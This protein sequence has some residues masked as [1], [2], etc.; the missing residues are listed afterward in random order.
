MNQ[1][2]LHSDV[3]HFIN[4]NLHSDTHRLLLK[5]S[6]FDK[7]SSKDLVTQIESK[8]RCQK[9]LPLWYHTPG[10][11]YPPTLSIEQ[12]SSELTAAYKA[13][14]ISGKVLDATGGL[15]VD[16]F[17]FSKNTDIVYHIENQNLISKIAQHNFKVLGQN[18][19]TCICEEA[20]KFIEN[21]P[22]IY[23]WI[24]IDPAR[25]DAQK[26]KVFLLS[27]C[28]PNVVQ[29][30]PLLQ[31]KSQ[32]VLIKTSPI[33]DISKTL[34]EIPSVKEI[35]IVAVKNEVKELLWVIDHQHHQKIKIQSINITNNKTDIFISVYGENS[36]NITFSKV[37]KYLYEPNAAILKSGAFDQVA[38]KFGLN[39]LHQHSHLYTCD[40][41]VE[42][43]G[44]VFSVS[45]VIPFSKKQLQN[46]NIQ[47]ANVS[48]R[49]FPM[50]VQEIRKIGKIKDSDTPYLYFTTQLPN[51]KI[52]IISE[53]I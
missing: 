1:H 53:K 52:I 40:K 10:I 8:K 11:Y 24:Y 50:S 46:L 32:N 34:S 35:H 31:K 3:Q 12:T 4:E 43:P 2:I 5:P 37:Q 41:L 33:L 49:N 30:L 27:D 47:C 22:E 29:I 9:K 25:R 16:S 19:I 17:Y 51:Q 6:L 13:K 23:D 48:A 44:R 18:N 28:S 45:E 36:K 26:N 7:V 39:K 14:L 42:F 21:S 20:H 38:C 15:G